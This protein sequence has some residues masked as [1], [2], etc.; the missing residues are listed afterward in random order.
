MNEVA[1]LLKGELIG[2]RVRIVDSQQK[3]LIG[4]E[5]VIADERKNVFVIETK[6]GKKTLIKEAHTFQFSLD[7]KTIAVRGTILAK[8]PEDRIKMRIPK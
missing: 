6:A 7:G 2:R 3:S 5:G 4:T 1:L 8:R